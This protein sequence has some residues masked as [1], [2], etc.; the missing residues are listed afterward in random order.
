MITC[1]VEDAV[2]QIELR[3]AEKLGPQR[4]N[5]W[6]K[7]ATRFSVAGE[8]LRISSPNHFIG[9]WIERHFA[10]VIKEAGREVTGSDFTLSFTI[11]PELAKGLS[12][13][14]PDR[15]LDFVTNNP[16]RLARQHKGRRLPPPTPSLK[17]TLEEFVVGASNRM[18][19]AAALAVVERP[20][21]DY[22]PLFIHGGCGLGKT[23]L[24]QA[25]CNGL[26]ERTGDGRS[27]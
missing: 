21:A 23:H 14:Q 10:E 7:N 20:A 24:L 15:Q 18:A 13:K 11:D 25:I 5:V 3:I 1:A 4:Y 19:Y 22:N 17:G 6:F 9:E 2:S 16:E 27:R 26:K 8:Y 12:K